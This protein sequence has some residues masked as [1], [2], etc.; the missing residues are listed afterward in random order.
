VRPK[1]AA[2]VVVGVVEDQQVFRVRP[3]Q[4]RAVR[5]E[6]ELHPLSQVLVSPMPVAVEQGL[7]Q[8]F[9]VDPVLAV[10]AVL[11]VA[12]KVMGKLAETL[13]RV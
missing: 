9:Q 12:E 10:L 4:F 1:L 7:L 3:A 2:A 6:V 13:R 5:A 8:I 11:E